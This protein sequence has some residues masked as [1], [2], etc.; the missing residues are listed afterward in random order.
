MK[1][2]IACLVI[3]GFLLIAFDGYAYEDGDFQYWNTESIDVNLPIRNILKATSSICGNLLK[4][5]T[6]GLIIM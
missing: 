6:A 1:Q 4:K 3:V 2:I 5:A